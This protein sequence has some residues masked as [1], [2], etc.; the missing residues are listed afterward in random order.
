[1]GYAKKP[2]IKTN[3]AAFVLPQSFSRAGVTTGGCNEPM[4]EHMD[5]FFNSFP[6]PSPQERATKLSQQSLA[7][8]AGDNFMQWAESL[9]NPTP[10]ANA[11][12]VPT[13]IN[14]A[15]VLTQESL[16]HI[17][18]RPAHPS[19]APTDP[20]AA[21]KKRA[22]G[23]SSKR[24]KAAKVAK[25]LQ[26]E[27]Y[28][29][30]LYS[31]WFNNLSLLP[32]HKYS[33][34]DRI[35]SAISES[36]PSLSPVAPLSGAPASA[37][38]LSGTSTAMELLYAVPSNDDDDLAWLNT[39]L[40]EQGPLRQN[41]LFEPDILST[42]GLS[43]DVHQLLNAE[44]GFCTPVHTSPSS[45]HDAIPEF[46]NLAA[47]RRSSMDSMCSKETDEIKRLRNTAA[48]RRSR[49]RKIATLEFLES[50]LEAEKE[51]KASLYGRIAALEETCGAYA[52]KEQQFMTRL[53][54]LEDS[55]Q[56][57]QRAE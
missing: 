33:V 42:A 52:V 25:K 27:N 55:V 23:D 12:T 45:S 36:I 29:D 57:M 1:M 30:S 19:P 14:M 26:V 35:Q 16:D 51:E 18:L 37:A 24:A 6:L 5:Q 48:A 34:K 39:N 8:P 38:A 11:M 32:T 56:R 43:Y 53:A 22:R 7:G 13:Q 21:P 50:R 20:P 44:T 10:S 17:L 28:A 46:G 4:N 47:G 9:P 54:I 49:A 40:N 15:Q 2:N 41:E 31:S 3:A